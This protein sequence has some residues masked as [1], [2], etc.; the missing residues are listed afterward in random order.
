MIDYLRA[1]STYIIL[2]LRQPA[3][4]DGKPE[5]DWTG[6]DWTGVQSPVQILHLAGYTPVPV[7]P[8][9]LLQYAA[10]LARSLKPSSIRTYLNIIGILH[11]EFWLPQPLAP[12]Q[13]KNYL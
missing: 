9:H 10:F 11:K 12:R 2:S 6:L 13:I 7:H 8:P 1:R 4:P 5:L 3:R